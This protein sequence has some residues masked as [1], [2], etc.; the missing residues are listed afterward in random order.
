M[1]RRAS[2]L[3]RL[4]E[5]DL[6]IAASLR[7]APPFAT[8]LVK[9]CSKVEIRQRPC[10]CRKMCA[11]RALPVESTMWL[12]WKPRVTSRLASLLGDVV[13]M[14]AWVMASRLTSTFLVL[15][16]RW[17]TFLSEKETSWWRPVPIAVSF[18]LEMATCTI[19]ES[20]VQL[21][22]PR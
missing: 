17:P 16:V 9:R 11:F 14:V 18:R 1:A 22:R 8:L 15:L 12:P 20:I 4:E 2:T 3:C 6:R 19:G 13:I 21:A 5:W 7:A 10:P